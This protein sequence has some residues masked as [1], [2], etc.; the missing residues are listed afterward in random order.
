MHI[1]P[2]TSGLHAEESKTQW[3]SCEDLHSQV[4]LGQSPYSLDLTMPTVLPSKIWLHVI[5]FLPHRVLY[6]LISLKT[7][8]FT[9]FERNEM[10]GSHLSRPFIHHQ[11]PS[12]N[13][14]KPYDR[15]GLWR[16]CI[17]NSV[18]LSHCLWLSSHAATNYILR[19][20]SRPPSFLDEFWMFTVQISRHFDCERR[21]IVIVMAHL[22][23]FHS[24]PGPKI[25]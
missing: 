4:I 24:D 8:F 15:S 2:L 16:D 3:L 22:T 5:Q 19:R 1:S 6:N 18:I 14:S 9:L 20:P 25:I 12:C 21:A 11:S 17:P 10:I 23:Q 7:T 13:T